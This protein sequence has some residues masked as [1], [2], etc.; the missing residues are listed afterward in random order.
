MNAH[1]KDSLERGFG[2]L[3]SICFSRVRIEARAV[4]PLWLPAFKG[5]AFRGAFG[6]AL[7]N[8][9][10]VRVSRS[11]ECCL[12][13]D[14]CPYIAIFEPRNYLP[15]L[16]T[17][18]APSPFVAAPLNVDA[19][20]IEQGSQFSLSLLLI[21]PA[22]D[23]LPY[24][25]L[26][27]KTVG[28]ERGLG[29]ARQAGFGLFEVI[30]AYDA[31]DDKGAPLYRAETRSFVGGPKV[32]T[33]DRYV[34][35]SPL[36]LS[37]NRPIKVLFSTPLRVQSQG[38]LLGPSDPHKLTPK[39]LLE[40]A[41]RRLYILAATYGDPQLPPLQLPIFPEETP[42]S[43]RLVWQEWE[44]Y[45]GRQR[46]TMKLGGVVG[47]MVLPPCYGHFWPLLAAAE[48]LHVGKATSFGFGALR[49]QLASPSSHSTGGPGGDDE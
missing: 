46:T 6:A 24:F 20:F 31:C 5:N 1:S 47:Q 49:C 27:W 48:L 33:V 10:C 19:E 25:I 16:A 32:H 21:G 30:A 3:R 4:S 14:R 9:V 17:T 2:W 40:A 35:A 45:S 18:R 22:T 34:E 43:E 26:A 15:W 12:V 29:K 13:A 42:L 36:A 38:H 44:R 37:G 41:Y 28:T 39:R 8:L 23:L 11:C 7:R